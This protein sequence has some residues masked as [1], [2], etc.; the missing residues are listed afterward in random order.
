MTGGSG[1]NAAAGNYFR[2]LLAHSQIGEGD[3]DWSKYPFLGLEVD[4]APIV[5]HRDPLFFLPN[6]L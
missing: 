1:P 6:R 3:G 2:I 5:H 4:G